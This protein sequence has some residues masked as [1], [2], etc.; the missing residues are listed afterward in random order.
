MDGINILYQ[1][2]VYKTIETYNNIFII[3][4]GVFCLSLLCGAIFILCL[5]GKGVIISGIICVLC[6]FLILIYDSNAPKELD[7]YKY[8]A[9]IDDSVTMKE[10][11]SKYD[12]IE[13]EGE[14]YTIVERK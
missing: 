5:S 3:L 11:L 2:P 13:Q 1:E 9:T 7:Y 6:F 10:F 4:F 14:I 8:K 12:I